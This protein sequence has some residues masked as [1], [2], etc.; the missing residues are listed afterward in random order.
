MTD[1][2]WQNGFRDG[3][4]LF[5]QGKSGSGPIEIPMDRPM[6]FRKAVEEAIAALPDRTITTQVQG[7]ITQVKE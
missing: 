7:R 4:E 6:G 5:S 2:I 3:Y 1:F